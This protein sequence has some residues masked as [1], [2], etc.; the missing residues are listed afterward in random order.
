[1]VYY[2]SVPD[3][4][5][6]KQEILYPF[7]IDNKYYVLYIRPALRFNFPF[8]PLKNKKIFEQISDQIS[9]TTLS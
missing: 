4:V 9:I 8:M 5:K 3:S 7:Y 1:M 6:M 2:L